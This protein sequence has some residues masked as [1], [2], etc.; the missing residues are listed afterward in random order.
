MLE[1][2][3]YADYLRG[4]ERKNR[5]GEIACSVP[6]RNIGSLFILLNIAQEVSFLP[7]RKLKLGGFK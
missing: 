1:A 2:R 4:M 3:R 6:N 5:M 7:L